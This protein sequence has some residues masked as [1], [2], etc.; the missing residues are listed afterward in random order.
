MSRLLS[1]EDYDILYQKQIQFEMLINSQY[2]SYLDG[3]FISEMGR[4][5]QDHYGE[6]FRASCGACIKNGMT[7]LWTKMEDYRASNNL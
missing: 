7:K 5:Y 4:I 1:K 3:P 2:I 6:P